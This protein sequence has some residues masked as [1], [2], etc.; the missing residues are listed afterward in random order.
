MMAD[1]LT[2]A[3]ARTDRIFEMLAPDSWLAQPIALRHPFIFYLGH[4]PAFAWNHVG[5]ALLERPSFDAAFDDLFSR[6]I[7]PDVDD[8]SRC[9]DHP[10]VPNRWPAVEQV[11]AYRD[12]VRGSLLDAVDAVAARAPTHLMARDSCSGDASRQG[13]PDAQRP[14]VLVHRSR[15]RRRRPGCPGSFPRRR[16]GR[17]RADLSRRGGAQESH[18]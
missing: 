18:Q 17:A 3:W 7:D 10:D 5:R 9:H 15:P 13:V 8:P 1:R 16:G 11:I 2:D 14:S 4:L 12:R 6:G